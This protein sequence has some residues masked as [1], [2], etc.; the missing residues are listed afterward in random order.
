[1]YGQL[2][3]IFEKLIP[4]AGSANSQL[5]NAARQKTGDS[6]EVSR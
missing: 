6:A 5:G 2:C 1:M 3:K 4:K